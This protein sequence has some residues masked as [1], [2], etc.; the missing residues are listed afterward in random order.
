M[1]D[2]FWLWARKL[3]SASY[4]LETQINVWINQWL[5][6]LFA[7][8]WQVF[9]WWGTQWHWLIEC[10]VVT[11][12][13]RNMWLCRA[14]A[15]IRTL[16]LLSPN[17]ADT[18]AHRY[19]QGEKAWK[20]KIAAFLPHLSLQHTNNILYYI[21]CCKCI[22]Y[23]YTRIFTWAVMKYTH[24]TMW[25]HRLEDQYLW[26]SC[27]LQTGCLLLFQCVTEIF[28][29]L[30][31]RLWLQTADILLPLKTTVFSF[32]CCSLKIQT[33]KPAFRLNYRIWSRIQIG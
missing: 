7:I 17:N 20:Q 1:T 31:F 4:Q 25:W 26:T 30:I 14:P 12:S 24:P 27:F 23:L 21:S 29:H 13:C 10:A 32:P 18:A 19:G 28:N 9:V 15:I 5:D 6:L 3:S 2:C 8:T 16:Q 22:A 33:L 11:L